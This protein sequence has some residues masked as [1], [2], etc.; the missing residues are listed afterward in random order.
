M[1]LVIDGDG[2]LEQVAEAVDNIVAN[3][4]SAFARGQYL[5][6][7]YIAARKALYSNEKPKSLTEQLVDSVT[8]KA[9]Q[10]VTLDPADPDPVQTVET[11][12]DNH[13][14]A[15]AE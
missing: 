15:S 13:V 5:T 1:T 3:L 8:G 12:I 7:D 10:H 9:T 11:I 6:P 2:T 4:L 14:H